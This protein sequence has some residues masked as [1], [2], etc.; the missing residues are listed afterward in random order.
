MSELLKFWPKLTAEETEHVLDKA[1]QREE[2][3]TPAPLTVKT[4]HEDT[5]NGRIFYHNEKS[6]PLSVIFYIHGGAYF[7]D[8]VPPHWQLIEKVAKKNL[9]QLLSKERICEK[10]IIVVTDIAVSRMVCGKQTY[11]DIQFY[12]KPTIDIL[13]AENR[14]FKNI[15]SIVYHTY[16][17]T[18]SKNIEDILVANNFSL[19]SFKNKTTH[20]A[21]Y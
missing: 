5:E 21:I 19:S 12:F 7:Y 1:M 4:R 13:T 18:I 3:K 20:E 15:A 11:L 6:K 17:E 9:R 10:D 8:I 16:M 14:N 2:T